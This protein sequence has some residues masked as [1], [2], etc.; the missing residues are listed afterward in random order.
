[1]DDNDD[2]QMKTFSFDV[3]MLSCAS[4]GS[5]DQSNKRLK[6]GKYSFIVLVDFIFKL[7]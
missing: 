2:Y 3:D 6:T 5:L 7:V 4:G 1:M